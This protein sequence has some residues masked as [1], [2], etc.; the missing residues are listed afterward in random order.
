MKKTSKCVGVIIKN[1]NDEYLSLYR[2]KHPIGLAFPAGHV[3]QGET[4]AHAAIRETKEETAIEIIEFKLLLH[5]AFKNS[6]AKGHTSHEWF[7]YE[8]IS[9][10]GESRL[11]ERDKHA[12]VSFMSTREIRQW[13]KSGEFD[14]VWFENILPRLG[15]I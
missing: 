4:S 11:C 14:P 10:R 3:D 2:L 8:A 6:C 1:E 9:W 7:I 12:F 5:T 15:I 13:I